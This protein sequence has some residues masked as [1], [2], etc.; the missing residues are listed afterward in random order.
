LWCKI[1]GVEHH[2]LSAAQTERVDRLQQLG[3]PQRAERTLAARGHKQ[4]DAGVGRVEQ[5]LDLVV[6]ERA[7]LP[8][9]LELEPVRHRVPRQTHL[10]GDL[11]ELAIA[12]LHPVVQRVREV[13][14]EPT[15]GPMIGAHRRQRPSAA[16]GLG[17]EVIH[18]RDRSPPRWLVHEITESAHC[19]R[20]IPDRLLTEPARQLLVSPAL[21]HR[22]ENLLLR[23][24]QRDVRC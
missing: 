17:S 22:G 14:A 18:I 7:T 2:R 9:A 4:L 12:D 11:P 23:V 20:P 19:R 21:H 24:R 6:R 1:D 5:A 15:D 13:V 16:A 10:R 3:I 8:I